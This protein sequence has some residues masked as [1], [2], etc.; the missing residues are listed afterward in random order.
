MISNKLLSGKVAFVT[1]AASG[2][3]RAAVIRFIQAGAKVAIVDLNEEDAMRLA[4]LVGE[5]RAIGISADV[6]DESAM[7]EAYE[8]TMERFGQLDI[9]FANAGRNGT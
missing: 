6:S 7:K 9:V 8:R 2:I 4:I 3:G 1:G 5:E